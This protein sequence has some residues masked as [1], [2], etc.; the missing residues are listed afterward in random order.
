MSFVDC[1]VSCIAYVCYFLFA[2]PQ[3]LRMAFQADPLRAMRTR[4]TAASFELFEGIV[5]IAAS[6]ATH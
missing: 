1:V 6:I 2:L 4:D 5:A 3:I